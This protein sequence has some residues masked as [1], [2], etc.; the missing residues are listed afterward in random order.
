MKVLHI[1]NI[2]NNAYNISKALRDKAGIEAD[3]FT[4]HY[5][6]YIS[7]PEWEDADLDAP[8]PCDDYTPVDWKS[9]NL[10]GFQR[11]EWYTETT[12][13]LIAHCVQLTPPDF[14]MRFPEFLQCNYFAKEE[15]N[16]HHEILNNRH[17]KIMDTL[18]GHLSGCKDGP[19]SMAWKQFLVQKSREVC[20]PNH[21]LQIT[22]MERYLMP[23]DKMLG[24]IF[25]H[26]DII[27]TYGVNALFS[28]LQFAPSVPHINFEHGTMRDFPL[29]NTPIGRKAM[30]AHKRAFANIITNADCVHSARK[31]GL[32]NYLFIPHPVDDSKFMV[33]RDPEFRKKLLQEH[34]ATSLFLATARQNWQLKGNDRVICAFARLVGKTGRGPKLLLGG[35]GQEIERSKALI[36]E[37]KMEDHIA[38]LPPL[39]K[40]IL[41]KY[42][43]AS[44]AIL[45]QFTLGI[46]GTTTPEAMA[47]GKPVLLHY[48]AA[49]HEWCL[50]EDPP[51]INVQTAEEIEKVLLKIIDNPG[52]AENIGK[53]S[54]EWF[55][56]FHSLDL[57]VNRHVKLYEK[58][59]K[60]PCCTQVPVKLVNKNIIRILCFIDARS[61]TVEDVKKWL[62]GIKG[63][64]SLEIL[65]KR[66]RS[67]FNNCS[68]LL[69]ANEEHTD[70]IE[71]AKRLTW[72]CRTAS[73]DFY[74]FPLSPQYVGEEKFTSTDFFFM[75]SLLEPF[76][77]SSQI[78]VWKIL[79]FNPDMIVSGD[80]AN[81][82]YVP[83][84]IYSRAFV[85]YRTKLN[86]LFKDRFTEAQC[87]SIMCRY[88]ISLASQ[89][90]PENMTKLSID[91]F[92]K[93]AAHLSPDSF[94]FDDLKLLS[95]QKAKI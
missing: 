8:P 30:F 69:A 3:C 79:H 42:I 68:F 5:T 10:H 4:D 1:G 57:V 46:F 64:S 35:W 27:Q 86:E 73:G 36:A 87:Q 78:E 52:W 22:D 89:R 91:N 92:N 88:G 85:E 49:D 13:E 31:M 19:T 37:L 63:Q 18:N 77:D 28:P 67:F 12:K 7:Q 32:N 62:I 26:Y 65:D 43:N 45:D 53:E 20:L 58:I 74:F 21:A 95:E 90:L 50:P 11:P 17:N 72:D 81:N 29:Q 51:V 54:L 39:P 80:S 71:E 44:D 33:T 38:W 60:S 47:C 6:H 23:C 94:S 82:P 9:I 48:N 66:L 40:K 59:M 75:C 76:I 41:A 93:V 24:W 25:S 84:K 83:L 2:A 16:L 34:D 70:L 55:K 61:A 56:Q 14:V 15:S